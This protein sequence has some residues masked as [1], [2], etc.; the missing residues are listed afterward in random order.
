MGTLFASVYN[1]FLGKI[2]E[3]MYMELT[4]QDTVRDLQNLLISAIPGFEFPRKIL[5]YTILTRPLT[6]DSVNIY[7]FVVENLDGEKIEDASSF[8]VELSS[9]EINIL[10]ILMMEAWLQRQVTSIENIRMKYSG[11]DFKMTS[12]ANHLSKLL[13]LQTEIRRQSLHMQRLYKR[14]RVDNEGNIKSNWSV[15]RENSTIDGYNPIEEEGPVSKHIIW[16]GGIV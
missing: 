6:E 5:D 11:T 16:D 12:Q 13:S 15:L 2:T 10:A 8:N 9:E 7:G 14:R 3:D 1:R 4:P